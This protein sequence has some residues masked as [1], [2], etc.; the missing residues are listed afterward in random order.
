MHTGNNTQSSSNNTAA[1]D[2]GTETGEIATVVLVPTTKTKDLHA[3]KMKRPDFKP[4]AVC[5]DTGAN[6]NGANKNTF[7]E[8]LRPGV[9]G[10][11]TR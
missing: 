9:E 11:T 7:W 4:K 1:W 8:D 2:V 6:K 10:R 5:S 3:A